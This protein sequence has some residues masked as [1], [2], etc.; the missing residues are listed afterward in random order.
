MVAEILDT[1]MSHWPPTTV[2]VK[3]AD[4]FRGYE[5]IGVSCLDM[6][7]AR[8]TEILGSEVSGAYVDMSALWVG[9]LMPAAD[10]LAEI[11]YSVE[12]LAA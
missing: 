6:P 12:G 2:L 9:A 4:P 7:G 8:R 11:G 1:D 10:A 5:F 3:L